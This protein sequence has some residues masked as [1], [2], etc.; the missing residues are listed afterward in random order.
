LLTGITDQRR[1]HS[2]PLGIV[3]HPPRLYRIAYQPV[4]DCGF[5]DHSSKATPRAWRSALILWA[6]L[7]KRPVLDGARGS[8][9]RRSFGHATR[10]VEDGA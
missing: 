3:N 8:I 10:T 1:G 4:R 6:A 2:L 7:E 5:R 9:V